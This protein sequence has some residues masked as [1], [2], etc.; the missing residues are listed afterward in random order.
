MH[1]RT[2][3]FSER[4]AQVLYLVLRGYPYA[5]IAERLCLTFHTVKNYTYAIRHM[6]GVHHDTHL[7]RRLVECGFPVW[8]LPMASEQK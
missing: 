1:L 3:D 8:A 2:I 4:Q 7:P 6:L 5:A